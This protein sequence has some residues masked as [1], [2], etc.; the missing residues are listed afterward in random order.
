V[1]K[2]GQTKGL[3][4]PSAAGLLFCWKQKAKRP[5]WRLKGGRHNNN[6]DYYWKWPAKTN[7]KQPTAAQPV[8]NSALT[9]TGKDSAILVRKGG[10]KKSSQIMNV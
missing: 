4:Q 3:N 6:T 2:P 5:C 7:M 8:L 10:N 1:C 9:G